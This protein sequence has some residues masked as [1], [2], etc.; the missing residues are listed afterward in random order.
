LTKKILI[1]GDMHVGSNVALMPEEVYTLKTEKE[2][3]QLVKASKIQLKI[4]EKWRE[5]VDNEGKFDAVIANGDLIDGVNRKS[6]GIGAW[7]TDLS[8]QMKTAQNLLKEINYRKLYGTQGS[9]YHTNENISVDKLVVEGIGGTFGYDLSIKSDNVRIHASH[10]I[11]VSSSTWQFRATGISKEL[12]LGELNGA[13]FEKFNVVV[14][15]HAHY[16]V[17]VQFGRSLGLIAPCWKARDEFVRMLGLG[18]NPSIGYIVLETNGSSYTWRHSIMHLKG[19][20]AMHTYNISI[21]DL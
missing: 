6:S 15:S 18:F 1:I 13:D 16:Y 21:E 2:N 4:L 19:E 5:M 11:G 8:V 9:I 14:R 3:S 10:K 20:D 12:V 7:T 17:A